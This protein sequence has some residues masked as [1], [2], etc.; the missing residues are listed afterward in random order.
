MK[1]H[2]PIATNIS[3]VITVTAMMTWVIHKETSKKRRPIAEKFIRVC[4][5]IL[6]A[7]FVPPRDGEKSPRIETVYVTVRNPKRRLGFEFGTDRTFES[8]RQGNLTVIRV[9]PEDGAG[10]V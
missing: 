10:R 6:S 9:V 1:C 5:K 7:R 8:I 3:V 2:T 4:I